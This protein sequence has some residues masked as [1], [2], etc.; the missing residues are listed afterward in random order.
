MDG[1][2]D[3][4]LLLLLSLFFFCEKLRLSKID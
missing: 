4:F 3:S 2:N 1:L